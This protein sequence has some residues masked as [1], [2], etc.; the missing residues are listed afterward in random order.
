MV[1]GVKGERVET[2][3][4]DAAARAA[5]AASLALETATEDGPAPVTLVRTLLPRW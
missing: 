3:T 1:K 2:G 4:F 5:A